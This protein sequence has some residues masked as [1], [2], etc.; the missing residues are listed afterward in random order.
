MTSNFGLTAHQAERNAMINLALAKKPQSIPTQTSI[1][2]SAVSIIH[3]VHQSPILPVNELPNIS[4]INQSPLTSTKD[5]PTIRSVTA[6]KRTPSTM[7]N[8]SV[9]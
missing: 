3:D 2:K 9:L 4:P 1:P 5:L 6:S 7:A 8:K